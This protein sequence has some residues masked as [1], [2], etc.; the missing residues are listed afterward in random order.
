MPQIVYQI[1]FAALFLLG[2]VLFARRVRKIR[3]NILLGQ[4][5]EITDHKKERWKTMARVALGQSK[6]VARPVAGILHLF[7]YLG[8][9]IINLEVLEIILDGLLG[10]HRIFAPL[11]ALYDLL[12]AS[13]EVLAILVLVSCLLFLVRRN[14]LK[15]KRFHLKEMTRWPKSDANIILVAECLLMF[16][17]LSMDACDWLLQSQEY[18][19]YHHAGSFPVSSLLFAPLYEGLS[20]A[21]LVAIERGMWWFHIIGILSFLV[22][23]TYS[24]HLHIILAFPNTYY[25]NLQAKGRFTNMAAVTNEVKLMMDPEADPYATPPADASDSAPKRFGAKDVQDLSWKQLLDAYSCTECGRCSSVCPANQTGKKLSPRKI[26]MDTRDRLEEVGKLIDSTSNIEEKSLIRDY[27]TEE[28]IWA[29]TSCNACVEACPVNIDPLSIIVDL[30]RYLIMEE[31]K[32]PETITA[33]FNN[34]E[35][36]GA[37]WAFS[38]MDRDKWKEEL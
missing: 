11:G 14:I 12:I 13:F 21:A 34:I 8:F 23:V 24:K 18:P 31:S 9:V 27:I 5:L 20:S 1:I 28:E 26:M 25:S 17:F 7:V 32:S 30:R 10:T 36:N 6:M 15:I 35:N 22:Y 4:P 29:C 19:G 3:R 38:A 16:A 2:A 37:P 33:M